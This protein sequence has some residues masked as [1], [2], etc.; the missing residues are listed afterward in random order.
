MTQHEEFVWRP[1]SNF[2]DRAVR[3]I[4]FDD[5][6]DC[7]AYSLARTCRNEARLVL[8]I[9][10]ERKTQDWLGSAVVDFLCSPFLP[11]RMRT[12]IVAGM[13]II[14]SPVT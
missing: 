3:P 2:R 14:T 9:P 13:L 4:A 8:E 5:V 7:E 10:A 12:L 1:K 6:A 11:I